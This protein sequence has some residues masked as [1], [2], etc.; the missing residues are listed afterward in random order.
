MTSNSGVRF[1]IC[2][3]CSTVVRKIDVLML[4]KKR[5]EF[6]YQHF[7]FDL[8]YRRTNRKSNYGKSIIKISE[9]NILLSS[10]KL[11]VK[12]FKFQI[13]LFA[14]SSLCSIISLTTVLKWFP[15]MEY[16]IS[17]VWKGSTYLLYHI[18][19]IFF[20]LVCI[21][22]PIYYLNLNRALQMGYTYNIYS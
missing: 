18:D 6:H 5:C 21:S 13:K 2:Q 11:R 20:R 15:V 17:T 19:L 22:I 12:I 4:W 9:N 16:T 14:N 10:R 8:F 7:C 3:I 1:T